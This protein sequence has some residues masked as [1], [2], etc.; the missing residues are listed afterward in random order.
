ME[1]EKRYILRSLTNSDLYLQDFTPVIVIKGGQPS[2]K[3][4]TATEINNSQ[5][6]NTFISNGLIEPVEVSE[7]EGSLANSQINTIRAQA[8]KAAIRRD[9]RK[10]GINFRDGVISS[11]GTEDLGDSNILIPGTRVRLKGSSALVGTLDVFSEKMGRWGITLG[12]GRTAYAL[13]NDIMDL[14]LGVNSQ[15]TEGSRGVVYA[16]DVLK[17]GV[18][19]KNDQMPRSST[20][21]AGDVIG[22][23]TRG[24]Y[25]VNLTGKPIEDGAR[26]GGRFSAAEVIGRPLTNDG[27]NVEIVSPQGQTI[28]LRRPAMQEDQGTIIVEG[29]DGMAEEVS[30][31]K[32]IKDTGKVMGNQLSH[33]IKANAAKQAEKVE[34]KSKY[35]LKKARKAKKAAL[36]SKE[37]V[38][39]EAPATSASELAVFLSKPLHI[40]KFGISRMKDMAKLKAIAEN[41]A[42][43]NIAMLA[44]ER[45]EQL[46]EAN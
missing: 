2:R 35:E 26:P 41:S 42:D 36:A 39:E 20:M 45:I 43:D 28:P 21:Q 9:F 15:N 44:M 17:R 14:D 29:D 1:K 12:D 32:V 10:E 38:S 34:K 33:A 25:A 19:K 30:L 13:E 37:E 4:F 11:A 40:Q 16:D 31:D 8:P 18:V 3:T 24:Q 23:A 6:I 22:R 27:T 46:K 5:D 7:T